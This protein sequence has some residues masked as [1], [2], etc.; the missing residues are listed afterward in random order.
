MI[1]HNMVGRHQVI[2]VLHATNPVIDR[3]TA[4]VVVQP[5]W[6]EYMQGLQHCLIRIFAHH[7][8]NIRPQM[9]IQRNIRF[10]DTVTSGFNAT[11]RSLLPGTIKLTGHWSS[12]IC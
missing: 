2:R 12:G 4:R 9:I 7:I 8:S 1:R 6:A 10:P 5:G 3:L 11:A